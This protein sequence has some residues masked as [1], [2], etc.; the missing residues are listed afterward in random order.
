MANT[1][2]QLFLKRRMRV[3]N[4]L[5]KVNAGRLRL[6]VHRSSKNIS[7]QLI[8]DVNGVTLASASSMEK[9]LGVVGKNNIEAA[10]KVGA[11]IAERAKKA[12]VEEAYFDRGGFLFHGK[13][14]ALAEAAREGGLKI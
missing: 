8:D 5:R 4:K 6:S 3:R 7:A 12:G 9:D 13:V 1:K 14:K 11:A 2:R 10:T